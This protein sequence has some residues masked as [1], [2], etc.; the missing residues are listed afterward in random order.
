MVL[1]VFQFSSVYNFGKNLPIFDLA[2]SGVKGPYITPFS[3]FILPFNP[4]CGRCGVSV[5]SASNL[6]PEGR[7]FKPW[8]VH[9]HCVL[10]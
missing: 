2:L 1:F 5:V 6:G 8:P 9:P 4:N 10:R 7:E 3:S